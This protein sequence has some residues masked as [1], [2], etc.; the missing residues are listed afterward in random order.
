MR[1]STALLT[2]LT[3]TSNVS[4]FS[5]PKSA[6][7]I[8]SSSQ[9]D[10]DECCSLCNGCQRSQDI[11]QYRSS[12]I[13]HTSRRKFIQIA[14]LGVAAGTSSAATGAEYDS[15]VDND[16]IAVPTGPLAPFS[17]TRQYRTIV[18]SNGKT[19]SSTLCELNE[20]LLRI[21]QD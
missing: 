3:I 21:T 2:A 18:L 15:S 19:L 6:I 5:S 1:K 14:S 20:L 13:I 10:A 8:E 16:I 4:A 17:S 7:T 11:I 12:S 9:D